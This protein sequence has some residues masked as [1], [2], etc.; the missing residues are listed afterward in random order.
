MLGMDKVIFH[1]IVAMQAPD[2]KI[3][4]GGREEADVEG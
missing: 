2:R 4:S 3:G 1:S